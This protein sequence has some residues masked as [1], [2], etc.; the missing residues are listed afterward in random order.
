MESVVH[1]KKIHLVCVVCGKGFNSTYNEEFNMYPRYHTDQ[2]ESVVG[3]C[4]AQFYEVLLNVY[5]YLHS[6]DTSVQITR[7]MESIQWGDIQLRK[8]M[9][10]WCLHLGFLSVDSLKRI[11]VPPEIADI[12][13]EMFT[14]ESLADPNFTLKAM[15]Y[16]K[17]AFKILKDKLK[18][19]SLDDEPEEME[20]DDFDEKIKRRSKIARMHTVEVSGV[21]DRNRE[22]NRTNASRMHTR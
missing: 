17:S 6:S 7:L 10:L 2:N 19:A 20:T 9:L 11:I 22:R 8:E 5:K 12:T 16:L 21:E 4:E 15:E 18:S 14:A 1:Q 13:K 3:E